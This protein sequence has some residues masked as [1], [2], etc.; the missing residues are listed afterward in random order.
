MKSDVIIVGVGGMG[1]SAAY[2]LSRR[3]VKVIGLE[4]Y[5]AAHDQGSSHGETRMIRKAYFEH[6]DYVPLLNRA[7]QL[8]Q[9]LSQNAGRTLYHET[10][11]FYSLLPNGEIAKGIQSSAKLHNL[12]LQILSDREYAERFERYFIVSPGNKNF[13]EPLAGYLEVENCT[14][15]HIQQARQLGAKFQFNEAVEDISFLTPTAVEVRTDKNKYS[16][17]KI[18]FTAGAWTAQI[19]NN[20]NLPLQV[21]RKVLSWYKTDATSAQADGMPCYFFE[22]SSAQTFYGFPD[23][24]GT[25][26]AGIGELKCAE[27]SGGQDCKSPK[28]VSR[29]VTSNDTALV[30]QFVGAHLRPVANINKNPTALRASVC[31][32]TMTP[33]GHFILDQHP[34]HANAYLACGFSGHG[35]KFASVI[36][37]C[38]ADLCEKGKAQHSINFLRLK[39]FVEV[40]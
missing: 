28:E 3:G 34:Q 20:L 37:E 21:R 8:W 29:I 30:N 17:A 2:H 31:M 38:L 12:P 22:D 13:F 6:A 15:A 4:K 24:R 32:Y 35:Y 26:P 16:A 39:R 11:I 33:D 19:L 1:A 5:Q 27:H 18:I 14:L 25:A 9:E 10:G 40:N 7:Y 23:V 36:G